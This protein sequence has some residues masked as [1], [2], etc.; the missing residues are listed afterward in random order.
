MVRGEG[1]EPFIWG[2]RDTPSSEGPGETMPPKRRRT[3]EYCGLLTD[4]EYTDGEWEAAGNQC[5]ECAV[6]ELADG[7]LD[8]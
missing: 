3:C 8:E 6:A 2:R 4:E 7:T 1:M 5:E